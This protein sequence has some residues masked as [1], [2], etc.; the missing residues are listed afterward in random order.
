VLDEK[1]FEKGLGIKEL[2]SIGFTVQKVIQKIL[3]EVYVYFI[4]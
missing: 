2:D 3:F 4:I 1:A